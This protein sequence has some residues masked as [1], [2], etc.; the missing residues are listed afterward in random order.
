MSCRITL[1]GI[2]LSGITWAR[3]ALSRI[4]RA[5][6]TLSRITWAR[7]A[8]RALHGVAV[9]P[10]LVLPLTAAVTLAVGRPVVVVIILVVAAE[11]AVVAAIGLRLRILHSAPRGRR[12]RAVAQNAEIVLGVLI[13]SLCSD[14]VPGGESIARQAQILLKDLPGVA[15]DPSV[16]SIAVE[17]VGPGLTTPAAATTVLLAIGSA[18]WPTSAVGTLSHR[19]LASEWITC[20]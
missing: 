2:T 8:W 6:V 14:A 18:A 3:V 19:P 5:R 20:R 7:V 13:V 12:V 4:T 1:S 15:A 10:G 11:V 17:G 16:R 9:V